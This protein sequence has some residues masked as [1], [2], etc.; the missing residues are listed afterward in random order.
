MKYFLL[1]A[2]CVL[3]FVGC[4]PQPVI[5]QQPVTQPPVVIERVQPIRGC[6]FY[7]H[8]GNFSCP[9]CRAN[10]WYRCTPHDHCGGCPHC[11]ANGWVGFGIHIGNGRIG[12]GVNP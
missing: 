11:R 12:I 3:M 4:Q 9:V 6:N 10:C 1:L 7:H 8:C 5:I 2:A